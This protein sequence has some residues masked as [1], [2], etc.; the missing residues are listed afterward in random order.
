MHTGA[1]YVIHRD[2]HRVVRHYL[3]ECDDDPCGHP[4]FNTC[5][6]STS[7]DAGGARPYACSCGSGYEKRVT[8]VNGR[9]L[10][11][12]RDKNQCARLSGSFADSGQLPCGDPVN[13][14]FD[15]DDDNY[16]C[17]C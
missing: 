2:N 5:S 12:C 15:L 4:V 13:E 16:N 9:L 1:L 17:H 14:C 8:N 6:K 7:Q 10:E 11:T 3:D